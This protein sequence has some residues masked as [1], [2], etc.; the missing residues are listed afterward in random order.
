MHTK[1]SLIATSLRFSSP[2]PHHTHTFSR[3][4]LLVCS[5]DAN[6]NPLASA[7]IS[8]RSLQEA[9]RLELCVRCFLLFG[10]P[11]DTKLFA[12]AELQL[13]AHVNSLSGCG[14]SIMQQPRL[15]PC[16]LNALT[17]ACM[18][19]TIHN[20]HSMLIRKVHQRVYP[21]HVDHTGCI[22]VRISNVLRHISTLI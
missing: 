18:M 21:C 20:L 17:D 11:R 10:A 5:M 9:S 19:P 8:T 1:L 15:C 6:N 16:C 3:L 2:R 12:T 7:K 13:L 14:G 22:C 4:V